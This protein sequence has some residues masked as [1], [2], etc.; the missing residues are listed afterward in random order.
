MVLAP[1][2]LGL[3]LAWSLAAPPG[4]G[5]ALIAQA[6]GRRGFMAGWWT[7]VGAITADL[8]MLTLTAFGFVRL[9]AGFP[10][11]QT[12]LGF[13]GGVLMAYF[14]WGAW[15]SARADIGATDL[16]P[17]RRS[18]FAQ[19]YLLI[20]TSPFNLAWWATAGTKLIGEGQAA[21]VAGFFVGLF[22]WIGAWSWLAGEGSRRIDRF[23]HYV[24]YAAAAV[25]AFFALY[26]FVD[27]T[28][29]AAA[30]LG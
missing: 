7:G 21:G 29:R 25:L 12:A 11:L 27:A 19:G 9:L 17:D 20:I 22:L 10:W 30:L 5:N 16:A 23:A 18:G 1:F 14:A 3:A 13:G 15:R 26:L 8:T 6:A 28:T 2:V 4:P 24:A